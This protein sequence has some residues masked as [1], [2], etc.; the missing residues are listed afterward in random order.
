MTYRDV[1]W[2]LSGTISGMA[3]AIFMYVVIRWR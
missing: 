2:Y 1:V 3:F